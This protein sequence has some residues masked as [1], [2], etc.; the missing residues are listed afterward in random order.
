MPV[1]PNIIINEFDSSRSSVHLTASASVV[2][3]TEVGHRAVALARAL[4]EV[5]GPVHALPVR[6]AGEVGVTV[7]THLLVVAPHA[8]PARTVGAARRQIFNIGSSN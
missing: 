4:L 8:Q 6:E 1:I 3:S 7:D 5:R 2:A